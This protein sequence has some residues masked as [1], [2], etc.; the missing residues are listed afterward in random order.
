M[1]DSL[2]FKI[3]QQQVNQTIYSSFRF[4][5]VRTNAVVNHFQATETNGFVRNRNPIYNLPQVGS[6]KTKGLLKLRGSF[7]KPVTALLLVLA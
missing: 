6:D 7:C 3:W 5:V 1:F 4:Y 2:S